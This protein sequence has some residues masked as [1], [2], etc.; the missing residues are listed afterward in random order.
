M[1]FW[2]PTLA[3][4]CKWRARER[5]REREDAGAIRRAG[6][7]IL[8]PPTL[9]L[10]PRTH[11]T[12]PSLLVLSALEHPSP[13]VPPTPDDHPIEAVVGPS[14][15]T[16]THRLLI[17]SRLRAHPGIVGIIVERGYMYVLCRTRPDSDEPTICIY[18]LLHERNDHLIV[19]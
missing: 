7:P 18:N 5:E 2:R 3:A 15:P 13:F 9:E 16:H 4:T 17:Q 14:R 11:H 1:V 10:P 12:L 6:L 19:C 8:S